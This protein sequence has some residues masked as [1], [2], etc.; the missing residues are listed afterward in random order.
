MQGL[1]DISEQILYAVKLKKDTLELQNILR[2]T[3]RKKLFTDLHSDQLKKTFWIN[4]YNA[5]FQINKKAS[6]GQ[7]IY[8][9]KNIVIADHTFSLDDIEHGILR[10]YRYKYSFGLLPNIFTRK[11]IKDLAVKQIDYRI[12]FALNC[13]AVS[14]PPIAFYHK[15]KIES[16]LELATKSFLEGESTFDENNLILYTSKLL[17]WYKHDFKGRRGINRMYAIYL[18]KEIKKYKIK[19]N[20]YS[21]QEHLDNFN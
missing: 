13:G 4:I 18:N 11:L 1:S 6:P 16:Q 20:P 5:Y 21:W 12:H 9:Q 8:S 15:N 3:K 19:Y 17:K 2:C 7:K 14:C 10:R